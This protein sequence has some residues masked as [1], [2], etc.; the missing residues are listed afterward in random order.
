MKGAV[1]QNKPWNLKEYR[2]LFQ[3]FSITKTGNLE[4]MAKHLNSYNNPS[5]NKDKRKSE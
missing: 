2:D 4:K 5:L 1:S 3:K